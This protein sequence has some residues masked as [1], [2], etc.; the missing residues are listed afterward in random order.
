MHCARQEQLGGEPA[1]V[2]LRRTA[3]LGV[4]VQ[5]PQLCSVRGVEAMHSKWKEYNKQKFGK[6]RPFLGAELGLAL[7]LLELLGACLRRLEG[8]SAADSFLTLAELDWWRLRAPAE[9]DIAQKRELAPDLV[10]LAGFLHFQ[11]ET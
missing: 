4:F 2:G 3:G 1:P 11:S 5:S 10:R 9:D 6:H 7:Y 8:R